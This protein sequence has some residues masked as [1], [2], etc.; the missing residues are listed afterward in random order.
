MRSLKRRPT[1]PAAPPEPYPAGSET[2]SA[3]PGG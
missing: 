2:A 1:Y 3:W